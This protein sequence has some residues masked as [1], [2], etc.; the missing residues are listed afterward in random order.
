MKKNIYEELEII[1]LSTYCNILVDILK[2]HKSLSLIKTI[3]FSYLLKKNKY[4]KSSVYTTSNKNDV[5]LKCLSLLSGLFKDY[6]DN[7][8]YIIKAIHLLID[9]KVLTEESGELI[10]SEQVV[11]EVESSFIHLAIKES[12]RYSDMQFLKEVVK[13]V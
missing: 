10:Y 7:I 13:N 12:K 2:R 1:L 8:P 3:T 11:T 6:N 4:M 9:S 5:V